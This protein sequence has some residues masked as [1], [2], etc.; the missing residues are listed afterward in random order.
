MRFRHG[1]G[2]AA[3]ARHLWKVVLIPTS[4]GSYASSR[5]DV[6]RSHHSNRIVHGAAWVVRQSAETS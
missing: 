5:L 2:N 6:I 4:A 3:L 1:I